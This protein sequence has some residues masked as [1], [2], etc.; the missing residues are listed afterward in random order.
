M[1]L[2]TFLICVALATSVNAQSDP[3]A[4]AQAA[5]DRLVVAG[6]LLEAAEGRRDRVAA[7]T[8]T[9]QAYEAGLVAMRDG[10]RGAAIRQ[11][12]LETVLA[13]RNG[14]IGRLLGALQT[15]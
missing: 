3:G 5:A 1:I 7:L 2:R 4:V 10:L 8:E 11:E 9:V 15:I 12:T 6:T 14:E 13:D